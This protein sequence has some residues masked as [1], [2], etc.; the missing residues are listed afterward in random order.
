MK[1]QRQKREKHIKKNFL[2][3]SKYT[4]NLCEL[5]HHSNR[6]VQQ[7][8]I[9]MRNVTMQ[10][11]IHCNSKKERKFST[12]IGLGSKDRTTPAISVILCWNKDKNSSQYKTWNNTDIFFPII[13]QVILP[14][15]CS[16]QS[17]I[18]LQ[19]IYQQQVLLET[20]TAY[21]RKVAQN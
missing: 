21:A 12:W 18:H 20:P 3:S 15:K 17:T 2:N 19:Q 14:P 11:Q 13:M 16:E 8:P 1:H 5:Q 6:P 9:S 10:I 7:I 4:Y